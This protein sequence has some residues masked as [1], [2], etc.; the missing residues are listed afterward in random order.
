MASAFALLL[1]SVAGLAAGTLLIARERDRAV[2]AERLAETAAE[3]A[4]S[5]AAIAQAVSNFLQQ[6]LLA[7]ADPI[8]EPDR[9]LKLRTVLDRASRSIGGRFDRQPLIEA[10]IRRTIATTYQSLFLPQEAQP[11]LERALELLRRVRGEE[12]PETMD[13][14]GRLGAALRQQD[15]EAEGE[16]MLARAWRSASGSWGRS[17]SRSCG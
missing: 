7:Q 6:D 15:R 2:A 17:T 3:Q 12:H 9:D 10:A 11:H 5:E 14:L 8:N 1:L 13:A 16:P 4:R